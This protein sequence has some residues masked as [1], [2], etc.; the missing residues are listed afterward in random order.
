MEFFVC[1][2]GE[3]SNIEKISFAVNGVLVIL[4]NKKRQCSGEHVS[5]LNYSTEK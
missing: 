3:L 4:I 1:F 5:Y 2:R